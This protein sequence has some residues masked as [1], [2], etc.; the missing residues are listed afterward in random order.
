MVERQRVERPAQYGQCL[1]SGQCR[2]PVGKFY[3]TLGLEEDR[4]RDQ[5]ELQHDRDVL[6][7]PRTA[8]EDGIEQGAEK[9]DRE[10]CRKP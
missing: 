8:R 6:N 10:D 5:D 3:D 2:R 4:Q 9:A 1:P 7:M